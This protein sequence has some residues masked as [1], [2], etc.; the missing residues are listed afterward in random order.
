MSDFEVAASN[1]SKRNRFSDGSSLSDGPEQINIEQQ[2]DLIS[3]VVQGLLCKFKEEICE[4]LTTKIDAQASK[5]EKLTQMADTNAKKMSNLQN[6]MGMLRSEHHQKIE[7]LVSDLK[8]HSREV[9]GTKDQLRVL[10][11]E[12]AQLKSEKIRV[13]N[14]LIDNEARSRR[15]NL[16][17]FGIPEDSN[18]QVE[19]MITNFIKDKMKV[20]APPSSIK[21]AHRLGRPRR[22]TTIGSKANHPRPII[23]NFHNFKLKEEIRAKRFDLVRPFSVAE[24]L[25]TEIREARKSLSPLMNELKNQNKRPYI[26]YPANLMCDGNLVKSADP[27]KFVINQ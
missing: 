13:Q 14:K 23:V 21:R 3:D 26:V 24:D 12:V 9:R 4:T 18:E 22:G 1:P 11:D 25:P 8:D 20:T 6:E 7:G 17:F 19:D 27:A 15:N 5:I 16:L 2:R 10:T